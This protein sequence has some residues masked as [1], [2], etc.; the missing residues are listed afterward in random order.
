MSRPAFVPHVIA[1]LD[2]LDRRLEALE[3]LAAS[4][5][6]PGLGELTGLLAGD[7]V[8]GALRAALEE[9]P[10]GSARVWFEEG[11]RAGAFPALPD[12]PAAACALR[13]SLVNR[14]HHAQVDLTALLECVSPSAQTSDPSAPGQMVAWHRLVVRPLLHDL[15][16][17]GRLVRARL[18]GE[19]AAVQALTGEVLA[20]PFAAEGF[21][22]R[23]WDDQDQQRKV[24]ASAA[25]VSAAP[26]V[27]DGGRRRATWEQ[28]VTALEAAIAGVAAPLVRADLL[29]DAQAL[30]LEG[31]RVTQRP[32]RILARVRALA[33]HPE[34]TAACAQLERAAAALK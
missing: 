25:R 4:D 33:R 15:R 8:L 1:R 19:S 24:A 23:A 7:D 34:L 18:E 29:R 3:G 32:A 10:T 9:T 20:G 30:R 12:E 17:I 28:L 2:L 6:G 14:V 26:E 22:P 21:G 5:A 16:L 31:W 11:L 27:A 13:W